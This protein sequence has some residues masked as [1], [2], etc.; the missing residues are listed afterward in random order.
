[1]EQLTALERELM[2][3]VSDL[4]TGTEQEIGTLKRSLSAYDKAAMSGIEERLSEIERVQ[5]TQHRRLSDL[6][7]QQREVWSKLTGILQGFTE[8]LTA[9]EARLSTYETG[10]KSLSEAL[11]KLAK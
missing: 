8:R 10:T 1:M 7:A 6:E 3:C 11:S 9:S 2:R 5:Q 4:L